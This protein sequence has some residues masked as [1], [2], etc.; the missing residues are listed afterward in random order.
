MRENTI[1]SDKFVSKQTATSSRDVRSTRKNVQIR[2]TNISCPRSDTKAQPL[3]QGT[4]FNV[5]GGTA[6][7]RLMGTGMMILVRFHREKCT[8][9]TKKVT[10]YHILDITLS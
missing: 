2:E 3:A 6:V 1:L 8:V 7:L 10:R 4:A 5:K 9:V